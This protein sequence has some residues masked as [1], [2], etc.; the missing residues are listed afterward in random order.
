MEKLAM[1]KFSLNEYNEA[2]DTFKKGTY[3][4]IVFEI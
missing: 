3:T 1:K 4:K 2:L